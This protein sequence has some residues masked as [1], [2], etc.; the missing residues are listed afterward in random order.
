MADA[1]LVAAVKNRY[2]LQYLTNLT[3]P[4]DPSAITI[5]DDTLGYACDDV[6]SDFKLET[7]R[8]FDNTLGTNVAVAVEGVIVYLL[9]RTGRGE[10]TTRDRQERYLKR[11]RSLKRR[12]LPMTTSDLVPSPEVGIGDNPPRPTFDSPRFDGITGDPPSPR[13]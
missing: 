6:E 9:S 11:I 8:K 1:T 2:S 4:D 13:P 10:K 7:G 5:D 3:N 12:I